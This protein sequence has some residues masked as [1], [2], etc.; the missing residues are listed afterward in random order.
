MFGLVVLF[1]AALYVALS[2]AIVRGFVA[3]ARRTGRSAK[4]WGG[5]AAFM[6]A[7]LVFWDALPTLV[8]H[9]YLCRTQVHSSVYQSADRWRPGYSPDTPEESRPVAVSRSK[10]SHWNKLDHPQLE[11]RSSSDYVGPLTTFFYTSQLIDTT[12][13]QVLIERKSVG[14]GVGAFSRGD[15]VAALKPWLDL[16]RCAYES[17]SYRKERLAYSRI[18]ETR[19]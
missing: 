11:V 6:L 3:W 10:A 17:E 7:M 5:G 8:A 15:S 2:V 9:E 13:E 16:D 19:K 18:P 1:A 4:R 12:N 14:S